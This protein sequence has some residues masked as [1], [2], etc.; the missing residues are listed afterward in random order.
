ME[1]GVCG[2]RSLWVFAIFKPFQAEPSLKADPPESPK[3]PT[4]PNLL[5]VLPG[6]AQAKSGALQA[7]TVSL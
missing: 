7:L 1:A 4:G 6:L 5:D 3:T 2:S